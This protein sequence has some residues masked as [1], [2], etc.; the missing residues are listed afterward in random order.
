M[1]H[2]SVAIIHKEG[3]DIDEMLAKYD[4]NIDVKP[5]IR[6]TKEKVIEEAQFLK[7]KVFEQNRQHEEWFKPYLEAETDEELYKVAVGDLVDEEG[8]E[9]SRYNPDSKWDWYVIGGRWRGLLKSKEDGECYDEL[10]MTE[11]DFSPDDNTYKEYLEEW[12]DIMS[13]DS[14][15]NPD[16]ILNTYGTKEEYAR[17]MSVFSTYAILTPEDEW[18]EPGKVGWFG[19]SDASSENKKKY[20]EKYMD[21]INRYMSDKYIMTIVDCHI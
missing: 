20:E 9:L 16:Y 12:E 14:F 1:S 21:I 8:N 7:K 10:P 11:I 15:Y 4:E 13:G 19:V 18:I 5:Y 3:Q 17:R 2:Y 6:R